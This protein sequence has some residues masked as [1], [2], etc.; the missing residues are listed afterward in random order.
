MLFYA[1]KMA[2]A[3]AVFGERLQKPFKFKIKEMK[4]IET[5]STAKP[6]RN[7]IATTILNT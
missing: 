2:A 5:A 4:E 1:F 3:I 7:A 6:P